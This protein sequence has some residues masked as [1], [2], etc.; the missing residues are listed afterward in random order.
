MKIGVV[1]DNE[2]T[3]DKRVLREAGILRKAGNEL[4]VLCF[5]FDNKRYE[6]PEGLIIERIRI[7]RRLKNIL[8]FF[9]N[10]IP[11][12]EYLWARAIKRFIN[13]RE[14]E[15]IHVHDLYMSKAGH[16]GIKSSGRSIPM[17]L[18]L[19]ENYPYA[20]TTYNWTR[21][22]IRNLLSR[23]RK[24]ASKERKYLGYADRIILLSDEFRDL[25]IQ[26]YPE[27]PENI[28]TSIPNV[29]DLTEQILKPD[30]KLQVNIKESG[31]VLFYFGV[32]AERRGIFDVLEVFENLIR[33]GNPIVLLII[34]P[35]DKKDRGKFK[36][37]LDSEIIRSR[38][39]Y[40]PW[41]DVSELPAYLGL[42]DIC[43]AP[44]HKNPQHESGIANKIYDYMLGKKPIVASDC[45]PQ[46]RLIEKYNCGLVYSGKEEM[47][48]AI[49]KLSSDETMR[50][51]MGDNGYNAIINYHNTDQ[52]RERLVSL[53]SGLIQDR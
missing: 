25:L 16:N 37:S 24:W 9:I 5:G 19:H 18:D 47:K 6:A 3:N 1:V 39:Y 4:F 33:E 14:L 22:F 52:I 27:L 29:P 17:V 41:I 20:V 8:F 45:L 51:K 40:L 30:V 38:I 13:A 23:P 53:Y 26:K 15:A 32:V 46:K 31:P 42:V 7:N 48:A 49:I 2:F 11:C 12:Y 28:F 34:G 50:E 43:L 36:N 44:F 10:L 35:V 21:G